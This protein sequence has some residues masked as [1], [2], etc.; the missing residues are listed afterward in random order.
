MALLRFAMVAGVPPRSRSRALAIRNDPGERS[1]R[2]RQ[3][4]RACPSPISL[5]GQQSRQI[6]VQL[7]VL[8]SDEPIALAGLLLQ[9]SS[10]EYADAAA[11][12]G[13]QRCRLQ[14]GGGLADALAPHSQHAGDRLVVHQKLS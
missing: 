7:P 9:S 2:R 11:A 4:C 10:V 12:I 3:L 6:A 13:D 8:L 1:L 14:P 5:A